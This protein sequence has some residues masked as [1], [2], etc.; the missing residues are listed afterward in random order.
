M[1]ASTVA[2]IVLH[3]IKVMA[4]SSVRCARTAYL[5]RRPYA[6]S[7]AS[8]RVYGAPS[9]LFVNA[10]YL[11]SK[12]A[13]E[14][15]SSS[16]SQAPASGVEPAL[17]RSNAQRHIISLYRGFLRLARS[18]PPEDRAAFQQL[19]SQKFREH[20]R[21]KYGIMYIENLVRKAER[22]LKMLSSPEAK[23][24][25]VLRPKSPPS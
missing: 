25:A 14:P 6:L 15:S 23:G 9:T 18:K 16:S 1:C 2:S 24:A 21:G 19:V 10:R 20:A 8:W 3:R 7:N 13:S 22:Q 5:Q 11:A 4:F 17:R 12:C